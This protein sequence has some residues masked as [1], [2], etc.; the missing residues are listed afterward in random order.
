MTRELRRVFLLCAVGALGLLALAACQRTPLPAP[1]AQPTLTLAAQGAATNWQGGS[2][3]PETHILYV[4]SQAQV[5][6]LGLMPPPPEKLLP[7]ELD[8]ELQL[9]PDDEDDHPLERPPPE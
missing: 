1:Q 5:S 7:L 3:D 4:S 8:D 6:A 9:D 2:Y